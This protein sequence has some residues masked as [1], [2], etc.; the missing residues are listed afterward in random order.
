MNILYTIKELLFETN[1]TPIQLKAAGF[2]IEQ[3]KYSLYH[4]IKFINYNYK[5]Y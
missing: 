4:H 5:F 2:A 3:K 1:F